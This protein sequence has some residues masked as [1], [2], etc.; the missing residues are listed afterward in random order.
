MLSPEKNGLCSCI[1]TLMRPGI[2]IGA[3]VRMP[4]LK[5]RFTSAS[6][7]GI[8]QQR[9]MLHAN[10]KD[11]TII[12]LG[13]QVNPKKKAAAILTKRTGYESAGRSTCLPLKKVQLHSVREW[14]HYL[15]NCEALGSHYG[16]FRIT[17][18]TRPAGGGTQTMQCDL[19][20]CAKSDH[21]GP[22]M[23]LQAMPPLPH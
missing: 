3:G 19:L 10:N 23:L 4:T 22:P 9:A 11:L 7:N 6:G 13:F 21:Q 17:L 16:L 1:A 2:G 15:S 12:Q 5:N 20:H 14:G 18:Q 8:R